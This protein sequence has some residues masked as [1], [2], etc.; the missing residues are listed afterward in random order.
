MATNL[1]ILEKWT[2][3]KQDGLVTNYKRLKLKASGKWERSL[4]NEVTEKSGV[5]KATIFGMDYTEFMENGRRRNGVLNPANGTPE[6]I[7]KW[8]GW[9]G[10]TFL[11]QWVIDKGLVISP[12]A[13][14]WKIARKGINVPNRYNTGGLVSDV[15]NKAALQDLGS[16]LIEAK[17][18]SFTSEIRKILK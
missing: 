17:V 9:A 5:L 10:S 4:R 18:E 8:V 14:A 16:R 1:S 12:F 7:K 11:K 2:L 15:I 6:A 13:V 3:E